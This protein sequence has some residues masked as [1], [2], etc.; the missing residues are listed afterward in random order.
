M[1]ALRRKLQVL[2]RRAVTV[3]DVSASLTLWLASAGGVH[4]GQHFL[5]QE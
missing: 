4:A 3:E 1:M 5:I 2:S